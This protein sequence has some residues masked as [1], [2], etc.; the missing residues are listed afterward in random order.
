M[1]ISSFNDSN[2][3]NKSDSKTSLRKNRHEAVV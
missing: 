2:R 1:Q 3:L